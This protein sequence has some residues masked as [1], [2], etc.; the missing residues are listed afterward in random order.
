MNNLTKPECDILYPS[1]SV[2]GKST[3]CDV[4]L[5]FRLLRKRKICRLYP[6]PGGWDEQ[7]ASGDHS[8]PAD[9][10]RIKYYRN[11]LYAHVKETMDIKHDDFQSI[12]AEMRDAFVR[13]AAN[14]SSVKER[15]WEA[16]ID[17]FLTSPL[18]DAEKRNVEELKKWYLQDI[19]IKKTVKEGFENVETA[20]REENTAT[21]N[22]LEQLRQ[23]ILAKILAD[24]TAESPS[25]EGKLLYKTM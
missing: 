19:E 7:P 21:R 8:L 16:A 14:L 1:P 17:K 20:V 12:W 3:D 18:T 11:T 10:V 2:Y 9:L 22:R 15:K 4:T 6:P 25:A 23:L 24:T 5:L 13:I